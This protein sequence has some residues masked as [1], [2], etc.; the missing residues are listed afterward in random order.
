MCTVIFNDPAWIISIMPKSTKDITNPAMARPMLSLFMPRM[1]KTDDTIAVRG[2][3][4][5]HDLSVNVKKHIGIQARLKIKPS[6]AKAFR[7]NFV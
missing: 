6:I 3:M 5:N 7:I 4:A 1:L 2:I